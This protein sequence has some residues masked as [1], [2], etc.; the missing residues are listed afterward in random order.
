MRKRPS[1]WPDDRSLFR[2]K[3]RR[4]SIATWLVL[5]L[6]IAA[7]VMVAGFWRYPAV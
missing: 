7:A 1:F 5:V 3:G 2:D 6:S 4:R